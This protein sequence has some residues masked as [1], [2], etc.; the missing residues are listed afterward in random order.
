M[1]YIGYEKEII[2][3][4]LI[5]WMLLRIYGK[6][7]IKLKRK[8]YKN[9]KLANS[10]RF[11]NT[12]FKFKLSLWDVVKFKIRLSDYSTE[13]GVRYSYLFNVKLFGLEILRTKYTDQEGQIYKRR[14]TFRS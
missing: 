9:K 12:G 3:S 10:K 1:F 8:K 5:L 2:S 14:V 13:K 6:R 4:L 7:K 11:Y